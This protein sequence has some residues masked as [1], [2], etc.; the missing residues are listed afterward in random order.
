MMNHIKFLTHILSRWKQWQ[1]YVLSL[2][3]VFLLLTVAIY[4]YFGQLLN[5]YTRIMRHFAL[6][7]FIAFVV[8]ACNNLI[9]EE[10]VETGLCEFIGK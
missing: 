7:L 8:L 10:I 6:N 5:H 9:A 3:S 1:P 2:S 4:T